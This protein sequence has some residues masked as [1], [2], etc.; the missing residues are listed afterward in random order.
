MMEASKSF[1]TES[2][3]LAREMLYDAKFML[4]SDRYRSAVDRAYYAMFHA[5]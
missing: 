3:R 1:W 2:L 5:S 4:Q